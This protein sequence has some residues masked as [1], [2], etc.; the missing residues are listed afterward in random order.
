M[1]SIPPISPQ[2]KVAPLAEVSP[3]MPVSVLQ[4]GSCYRHYKG[5]LYKIAGHCIIEANAEPG[6]LY[7]SI[8]PLTSH[9]VWMRPLSDFCAIIHEE[10]KLARFSLIASEPID[11]LDHYLPKEVISSELRST[12]LELHNAVDR[13]FH[14]ADNIYATFNVAKNLGITLTAEQSLAVLF[15]DVINVPGLQEGTN[16]KLSAMRALS[17]SSRLGDCD[18]SKVCQFIEDTTSHIATSEESALVQDLDR[19]YLAAVPLKFCVTEELIWLENRHLVDVKTPRQD[20]DTRRLKY[21]LTEAEK[22]SIFQTSYFQ[23]HKEAVA[24]NIEGLRLAWQKKY[25]SSKA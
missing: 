13:H 6:V 25:G 19:A 3:D 2:Q 5:G 23:M 18:I 10:S 14:T 17:Y 20:F 16:E 21:L 22:G 9:K 8:D 11:A 7:Q 1:I 12:I 24:M 4:P 15:K